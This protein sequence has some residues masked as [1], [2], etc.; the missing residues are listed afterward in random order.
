[1]GCIDNDKFARH[2]YAYSRSFIE[3]VWALTT[4]S[5]TYYQKFS[6]DQGKL[7]RHN[8]HT[9]SYFANNQVNNVQL[10]LALNNNKSP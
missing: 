10:Q 8:K 1:M 9:M 3:A 2:N 6:Q 5:S 7:L 4:I